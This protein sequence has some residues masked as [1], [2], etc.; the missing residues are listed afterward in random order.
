MEKELDEAAN[1]P[2]ES[3]RQSLRAGKCLRWMANPHLHERWHSETA[4]I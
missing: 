2:L 3:S 1:E 4:L